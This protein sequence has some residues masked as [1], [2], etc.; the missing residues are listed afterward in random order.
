MSECIFN[1]NVFVTNTFIQNQ[2]V[3][4][5]G[6]EQEGGAEPNPRALHTPERRVPLRALWEIDHSRAMKDGV[7][8]NLFLP[9]CIWGREIQLKKIQSRR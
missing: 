7:A 3:G 5:R 1:D 2:D 6:W 9:S 8:V 4:T